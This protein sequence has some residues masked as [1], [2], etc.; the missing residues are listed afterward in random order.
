MCVC[1]R[2]SDSVCVHC[3]ALGKHSSGV[4]CPGVCACVLFCLFP[5][6]VCVQSVC[7]CVCMRGGTAAGMYTLVPVHCSRM[8][9]EV[10]CVC[11][12]MRALE[13]FSVCVCCFTQMQ[14]ESNDDDSNIKV[15][16]G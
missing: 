13:C 15:D 9:T 11:V 4:V 1:L 8:R 5:L 3:C 14:G 10:V 6:C 7:V 12:H 2:E 16:Q